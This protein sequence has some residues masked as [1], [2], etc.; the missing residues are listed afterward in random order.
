[1]NDAAHVEELVRDWQSQYDTV[2]T[3][4]G[5]AKEMK[6]KVKTLEA[7]ILTTMR[8]N[9]VGEFTCGGYTF[10]DSTEHK[11]SVDT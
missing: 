8:D 1:M 6:K 11:L 5:E 7:R 3:L 9:S 4:N 10:T 2:Q